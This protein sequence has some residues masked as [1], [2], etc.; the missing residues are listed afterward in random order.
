MKLYDLNVQSVSLQSIQ[1]KNIHKKRLTYRKG[2][3]QP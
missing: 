3:D 2:Q 1:I